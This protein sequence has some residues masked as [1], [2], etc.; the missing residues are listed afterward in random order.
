MSSTFHQRLR[1]ER[2][3]K[4]IFQRN[5]K[6]IEKT[7]NVQFTYNQQLLARKNEISFPAR[8]IKNWTKFEDYEHL[9]S[10]YI[11][12]EIKLDLK[13]WL[14]EI[15]RSLN[16]Y[17]WQFNI[18]STI[19]FWKKWNLI[20]NPNNKELKN[21]S[22]SLTFNRWLHSENNKTQ[23]QNKMIKNRKTFVY[24]PLTVVNCYF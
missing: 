2:K 18:L 12:T 9:L 22:M 3:W 16:N 24:L 8:T 11:V 1:P 21:V 6:K 4:S 15:E 7:L 19:T 14:Y 10:D 13:C 17:D 20:F 23:F 5:D